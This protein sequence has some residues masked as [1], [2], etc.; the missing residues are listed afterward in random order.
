MP[1]QIIILSPDRLRLIIQEETRAGR[2]ERFALDFLRLLELHGAYIG[3]D[4][5]DQSF[6]DKPPSPTRV[7]TICPCY[8]AHEAE[9]GW[10]IVEEP[11]DRGH[12]KHV[13]NGGLIR[14]NDNTW[15]IHT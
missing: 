7:G 1:S 9:F 8:S 3:P 12:G 6:T 10:H 13:L 4:H 15:G 5:F 11:D 14:H 2:R